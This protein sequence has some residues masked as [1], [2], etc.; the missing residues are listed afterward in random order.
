MNNKLIKEKGMTLVEMMI[1]VSILGIL[2]S[3]AVPNMM[4][5]LK[6]AKLSSQSDLLITSLNS[7]RLE[8]IKQK[9]DIQLCPANDANTATACSSNSADWSKGWIIIQTSSNTV[10][11]RIVVQKKIDVNTGEGSP[12]SITFSSTYGSASPA[13]VFSICAKDRKQQDVSVSLSGHISKSINTI[14]CT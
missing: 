11:E 12:T 2:A 4:D 5:L 13:T 7:A 6:D 1:A 9:K 3:V 8:A 14:V 10:L